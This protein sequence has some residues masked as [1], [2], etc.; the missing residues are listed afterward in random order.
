MRTREGDAARTE[1]RVPGAHACA[2]GC[3]WSDHVAAAARRNAAI[4]FAVTGP[5]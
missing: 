5:G 4:S 2:L 1:R 3:L